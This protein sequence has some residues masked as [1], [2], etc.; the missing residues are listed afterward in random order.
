MGW[1][2]RRC[3]GIYSNIGLK[4]DIRIEEAQVPENLKIIIFRIIQEAVNN[5]AKHSHAR[6]VSLG[7]SL[8]GEVI[9][10]CIRDDGVGFDP[11]AVTSRGQCAKFGLTSMRERA[12][13]SGGKFEIESTPGAGTTISVSWKTGELS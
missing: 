1:F 3:E 7:L 12:V 8:E 9:R 10:L 5:S 11:A 4:R 2:C 6:E 13:L